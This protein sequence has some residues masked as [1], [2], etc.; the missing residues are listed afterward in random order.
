MSIKSVF[1][2]AIIDAYEE[3][4]VIVIDMLGAF[5]Q[6]DDTILMKLRC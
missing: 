6:A 3:R 5:M 4:D 2:T 1:L